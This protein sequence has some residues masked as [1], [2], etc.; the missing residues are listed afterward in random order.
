MTNEDPVDPLIE[1]HFAGAPVETADG[2]ETTQHLG[3]RTVLG[4]FEPAGE[5]DAPPAEP[6]VL[7]GDVPWEL[8]ESV[9]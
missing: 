9:D 7:L 8:R 5:F 4:D 6:V 1:H 2:R 3:R